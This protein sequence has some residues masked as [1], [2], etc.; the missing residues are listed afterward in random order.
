MRNIVLDPWATYGWQ[1]SPWPNRKPANDFASLLLPSLTQPQ[2]LPV[3]FPCLESNLGMMQPDL[4]CSMANLSATFAEANL[5]SG[6]V[7]YLKDSFY[8]NY[9]MQWAHTFGLWHSFC[10]Y[11]GWC[12]MTPIWVGSWDGLLLYHCSWKYNYIIYIYTYIYIV[13]VVSILSIHHA[14]YTYIVYY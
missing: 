2:S 8:I 1:L 14:Y 11:L 13:L 5:E 12:K 10:K 4:P 9:V 6:N 3:A 7:R